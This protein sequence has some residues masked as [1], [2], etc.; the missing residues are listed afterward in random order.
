MLNALVS[1]VLLAGQAHAKEPIRVSLA[2]ETCQMLVGS[3]RD[4]NVVTVVP[5][6][7]RIKC[8]IA[9]EKADCGK[10]GMFSVGAANDVGI[11][12]FDGLNVAL[13]DRLHGRFVWS[14][15]VTS[16]S[17]EYMGIGQKTCAGIAAVAP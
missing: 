1:V 12:L 15:T 17:G 7:A 11:S 5:E 16:A 6:P 10:A 14:T 3:T 4:K 9:G 8:A 13:I 2:S